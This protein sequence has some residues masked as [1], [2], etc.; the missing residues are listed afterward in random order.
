MRRHGGSKTLERQTA[1]AE[2]LSVI[3]R[4]PTGAQATFD[5]L[6]RSVALLCRVDLSGE[7][8]FDGGL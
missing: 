7:H 8:R 6:A 1:T 2:I 5:A 3:S 4:S